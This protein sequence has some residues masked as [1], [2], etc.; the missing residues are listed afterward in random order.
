MMRKLSE[1]L[2]EAH[3]QAGIVAQPGDRWGC[4]CDSFDKNGTYLREH[5]CCACNDAKFVR[6]VREVGQRGFGTTKPCRECNDPKVAPMSFED[7]FI[8]RSR[9]PTRYR[10][11]HIHN[12]DA[13]NDQPARDAAEAFVETWPPAKPFLLLESKTKGNG[14]TLLACGCVQEVWTRHRKI[15]QFWVVG[16]LLDTYRRA[17]DQADA[18]EVP[19]VQRLDERFYRAPLLVLDD[20]GA[21]KA[22]EWAVERLYGIVNRR[23]NEMMPTIFTT[24]A[25]LGTEIDERIASRIL[26]AATGTDVNLTGPDR[27]AEGSRS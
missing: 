4:G 27:R 7:R 19:L 25:D 8:E 17:Y 22:T 9:I 18:G 14:K 26:D 11:L 2:P 12:F 21:E 15:G 13:L 20:L 23:Y 16:E 10:G 24:N 6:L 5:K 1:V 3:D